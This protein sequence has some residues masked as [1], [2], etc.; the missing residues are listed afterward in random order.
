MTSQQDNPVTMDEHGNTD[1]W[2][3]QE[4]EHALQQY[5]DI[6]TSKIMKI[7]EDFATKSLRADNFQNI[8]INADLPNVHQ[9]LDTITQ[10]EF[11]NFQSKFES[12]VN[13]SQRLDNLLTEA[14][15][16]FNLIDGGNV[17]ND[18]TTTHILKQEI[19]KIPRNTQKKITFEG[20]SFNEIQVRFRHD[21]N[22]YPSF[23]TLHLKLGDHV[24]VNHNL[25]KKFGFVPGRKYQIM[26][27]TDH[28]QHDEGYSI[29]FNKK[30]IK[31][32]IGYEGLYMRS[33]RYNHNVINIKH[34][35]QGD[36]NQSLWKYYLD[37]FYFSS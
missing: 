23:A 25:R 36:G 17:N 34:Q 15:G 26:S 1:V 24:H 9:K 14:P 12:K 13:K 32:F 11:N 27:S 3:L 33:P 21:F 6:L 22:N 7:E 16:K 8:E 37:V 19:D 5:I 35:D 28:Y 20:K 18:A 2:D 10:S 31:V 4:F 30:F 29:S